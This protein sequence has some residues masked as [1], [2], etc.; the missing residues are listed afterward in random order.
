MIRKMTNLPFVAA[1]GCTGFLLVAGDAAAQTVSTVVPGEGG[2]NQVLSWQHILESG[3]W[4]MFVLAAMSVL[5]VALVLYFFFILR[6]SQV[7]PRPLR[8]EIID[9]IEAGALDEARHACEY[10]PCPLSAVAVTGLQYVQHAGTTNPGLLKDVIQGEGTRQAEAIE[11][12]TQY[13][14][15]IGAIAPMVGLL[16]TVFGMLR[17]FSGVALDI[18]NAKPVVLAGGV[19]QALITT[20]CGLIIGIP[21]MM[22]YAYFR[23]RAAKL[24]SYLESASVDVL[25]ALLGKRSE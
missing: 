4:L 5:A 3:G 14:L 19:S 25:T 8:R 20:A 9:K 18:A 10:R 15:D 21:S 16:G 23:R 6:V 12:Q 17:A 24:V 11:G 22:F 7:A 2:Q 1:G 13:L